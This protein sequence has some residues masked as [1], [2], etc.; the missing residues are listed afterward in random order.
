MFDHA[1]HAE[2]RRRVYD[3]VSA[4]LASLDDQ[5]LEALIQGAASQKTNVRGGWAVL[6]LDGVQVFAKLVPLTEL[7]RAN[8]RSTVNMFGLPLYYQYGV[9]STGFG[10][11]RELEANIMATDWVLSGQ[12][13]NFPLLYHW[14]VL[15]RVPPLPLTP[16]QQ[17]W[18]DRSIAYWNGSPAIRARRE[19]IIAADA[20]LVMFLEHVPQLVGA[21]LEDRIRAGGEAAEA[22]I[23]KVDEQLTEVAR[24]INARGMLHFDPHF[25]NIL[26]DG[27]LAYVTDFGL[28]T[29]SRFELSRAERDFF[30]QHR[31][32][33]RG[34][35]A[36]YLVRWI[37]ALDPPVCLS[38]KSAALTERYR[39]IEEVIGGFINQLRD[40][41]KATPYP[42]EE[43]ERALIAQ[44][45]EASVL[46]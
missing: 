27:E 37:E 44:L 30:E 5:T 45:G 16:E 13:A 6:D 35:I 10:V 24:F 43:L 4:R 17:E 2:R 34:Y 18:L 38:P 41:S 14:R 22:A 23:A 42:A 46:G 3:A 25:Q 7:E 39:P 40:G 19:A 20:S 1:A 31:L 36:M 11:W 8:P 33:D 21:W 29:C 26:T 28:A 32:Y 9:G 12:C 15:P